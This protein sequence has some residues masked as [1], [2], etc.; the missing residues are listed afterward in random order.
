[1]LGVM[2]K[3]VYFSAPIKTLEHSSKWDSTHWWFQRYFISIERDSV[4]F[5]CEHKILLLFCSQTDN[6][7]RI[8]SIIEK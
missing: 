3:E 7:T 6:P 4:H 1:M 5:T 2:G 8:G